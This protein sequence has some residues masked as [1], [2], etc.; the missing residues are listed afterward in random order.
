MHRLYQLA[1][2]RAAAVPGDQRQRLGHQVQ[3][4]QQVRHPPLADRR[5][6]PRHRRA[7][8]RQGRRRLRLRRRGQGRGRVA[9]R[10]GRPRRSSPRS[11]RSARCRRRWTATRSPASRTSSATADIFITATGSNDVI[12]A[13][14]MARMKHKAIVGN[15]GHFDNEIDM[16]GLAEGARHRRKTEIKPQVHEWTL[17]RTASCDHR[18]VRGPAA[19]PR[20]RHR[21]PELRD[22]QLVHQPGARPDRAVHQARRVRQSAS[23]CC[24]STWTRRSPACTSDA[25]GVGLTELTKEQAEYLGVDVAGP[26][27]PDHYRY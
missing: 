5:P 6:Q 22:E 18:A 1:E 7:D 21:P 9:A 24:P 13:E 26:Y 27:K 11:T 17:R 4:R 25:L 20:Q 2:A 10:P 19:E 8:R 16:A 3:V 14:H 23:T 15:I 12:T